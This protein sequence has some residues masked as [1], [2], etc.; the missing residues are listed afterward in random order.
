MGLWK[1]SKESWKSV[2]EIWGS[3]WGL[4][5][6]VRALLSSPYF[7]VSCL[8]TL[9]AFGFWSK[10]GWWELAI[11]IAPTFLGFSLAGLAVFFSMNDEKF[12]RLIVYKDAED[13]SS[14]FLD[15]VVAFIHFV[16]WQAFAFL[17]AMVTKSL[18]F[19]WDA[20]PEWFLSLLPVGNLVVWGVGFLILTYATLL[21][22][23]ATFAIFR[24]ARWYEQHVTNM[25]NGGGD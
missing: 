7:H 5:G 23:A 17:V 24:A 9:M 10:P 16:V 14:P 8:V 3:Y 25:V 15:I 1:D 21:L 18:F 4:Y 22:L 6:G 2:F 11:T 12:K 19:R 20:A 13:P